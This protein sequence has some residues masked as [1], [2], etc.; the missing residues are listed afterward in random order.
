MWPLWSQVSVMRCLLYTRLCSLQVVRLRLSRG[1]ASFLTLWWTY[2]L[3]PPAS[4]RESHLQVFAPC[5]KYSQLEKNGS[6]SWIL[7]Q[8]TASHFSGQCE[9]LMPQRGQGWEQSLSVFVCLVNLLGWHWWIKWTCIFFNCC[10][11]LTF[12]LVISWKAWSNS[13]TPF[14][15]ERTMAEPPRTPDLCRF[16]CL[17]PTKDANGLVLLIKWQKVVKEWGRVF[18][19]EPCM[20]YLVRGVKNW[21]ETHCPFEK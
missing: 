17:S 20:G 15:P 4:L 7:N 1:L 12:H 9:L 21:N 10:M 18:H 14:T 8:N 5:E 13:S 6:G 2:G 3:N 19:R 16:F 11:E